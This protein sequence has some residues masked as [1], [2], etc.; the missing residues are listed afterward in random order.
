MDDKVLTSPSWNTSFMNHLFISVPP[1]PTFR[2]SET[3]EITVNFNKVVD[4]RNHLFYTAKAVDSRNSEKFG[5]CGGPTF[6][7]TVRGLQQGRR[8]SLY[9]RACIS[10]ERQI[11]SDYSTDALI[12]YT[13]SNSKITASIQ[14]P[15]YSQCGYN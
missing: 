11:C 7:C 1:T 6:T 8:Y 5:D 14:H 12:A 13:L 10:T 2:G 9:V 15:L 4:D 3:D